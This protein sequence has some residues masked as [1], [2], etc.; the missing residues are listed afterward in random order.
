MTALVVTLTIAAASL[1]DVALL[2][3]RIEETFF[4]PNPLPPPGP[5]EYGKGEIEPGVTAVPDQLRH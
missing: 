2:R 1:G 4:V 5:R 3:Q